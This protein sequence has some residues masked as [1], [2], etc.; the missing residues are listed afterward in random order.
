M[1]KQWKRELTVVWLVGWLAAAGCGKGGNDS[2]APPAA[3]NGSAAASAGSSATPA[4]AEDP[5]HPIVV[6][7]TTAGPIKVRLDAERARLT[8]DNFLGYVKSGHYDGTIFHQV[9]QGQGVIGGGYTAA[10][11]EKPPR[12]PVRNEAD[13]GLKN[14]RG[15]IAMLRS[16]DAIDS[17][18]AQFFFN[19]ADNP[20]LDHR[21]RTT[22][23]YGYCVF[24]EVI[25]GLDVLDRIGAM[26]VKDTEQFDHM[27][28]ETVII[29]SVRALK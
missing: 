1:S 21:D 20:S 12:P 19:L 15:T 14:R 7:D 5:L 16:I 24:G 22:E 18:Q 6:F 10:L 17:A 26:P 27:P 8:V 13:N 28:V 2:S 3:L 25:E 4:A 9:F 29:R 11:E 23:G